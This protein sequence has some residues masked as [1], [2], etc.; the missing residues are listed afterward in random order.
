MKQPDQGYLYVLANSSM[1]GLVKVGKT[2]R[3]PKA[4]GKELSGASGLPTPFIVVFEQLFSDCS[5]AE[6]FVHTV[7]ARSGFR[8]ADNREFFNAPVNDVVRAILSAPGAIS[9][10]QRTDSPRNDQSATGVTTYPWS[11]ALREAV[12]YLHG[13]GDHIQSEDDALRHFQAAEK[14][15]SLAVYSVLG[16]YFEDQARQTAE[17]SEDYEDP[18]FSKAMAYYKRGAEKGNAYCHWRMGLLYWKEIEIENARKCF[19]MFAKTFLNPAPFGQPAIIIDWPF[20]DA[21]LSE[22]LSDAFMD[23]YRHLIMPDSL[24]PVLLYRK[25]ALC[26]LASGSIELTEQLASAEV[27]DFIRANDRKVVDFLSQL[28]SR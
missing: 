26:A 21:E 27:V 20:L 17:E 5:A 4:R 25:E 15:G 11:D 23:E 6:S 14:L 22:Y 28:R 12:Y 1:P 13:F 18:D 8:V 2:T 3:T 10:S 7:L 9:E 19:A 24:N 16:E